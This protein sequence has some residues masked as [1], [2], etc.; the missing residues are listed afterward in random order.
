MA[1]KT[2]LITGVSGFVGIQILKSFVSA[3]YFVRGS[4]RTQK[5]AVQVSNAANRLGVLGSKFEL[6]IVPDITA[7]GSFDSH[8]DGV[9]GIVHVASPFYYHV[10]KF[11]DVYIPAVHGTLEILKS[12]AKRTD[13]NIKRVVITSSFAA[14]QDFS[15]STQSGCVYTE[16]DWNLITKERA[17]KIKPLQ[18]A[19]SK[20]LAEVAAW[21]FIEN[22]RPSFSLATINPPMIYGPI[23]QTNSI[24]NLNQSALDIWNLLNG[25]TK[26]VPPTPMPA[27][28][29]VRDVAEAHLKAFEYPTGG[30]FLPV[31]GSFLFQDICAILKEVAP[32]WAKN[33]PNPE[34]R[35]RNQHYEVNNSRTREELN[36]SF[37]GL[38]E[39]IT[40]MVES[41]RGMQP[42]SKI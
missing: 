2:V 10:K 14:V 22:E 23:A 7:P 21:D 29:D 26:E 40:D 20:K 13:G 25:Q 30:R 5:S 41:Y 1:T 4:V 33:V 28:C 36:I 17:E 38:R 8:L 6:V 32:E 3:G 15:K 31:G 11:D 24:A 42:A 34:S 27:Y 35:P 18:Y 9:D 19:A 39:T 37:R 16:K 12:A